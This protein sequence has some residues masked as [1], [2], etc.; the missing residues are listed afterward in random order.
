LLNPQSILGQQAPEIG[1][2]DIYPEAID[3]ARTDLVDFQLF[4]RNLQISIQ[5]PLDKRIWWI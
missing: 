3:P 1:A 2:D 4:C 5:K